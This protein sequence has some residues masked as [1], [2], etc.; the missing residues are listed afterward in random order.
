MGAFVMFLM[1][2]ADMKDNSAPE[3]TKQETTSKKQEDKSV[4]TFDFYELLKNNDISVPK[5]NGDASSDAETYEPEYDYLLQVASFKKKKDAEAVK[6]ELLLLNMNA[7]LEKAKV[8][9]GG[10]WHRVIVGPFESRSVLAKTK[11]TLLSNNY[12]A[13]L[14]KRPKDG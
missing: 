6:V 1:R 5:F 2:L 11:G 10:T 12:S 7:T 3:S 9:G 8:D 4:P 13:L 14:L